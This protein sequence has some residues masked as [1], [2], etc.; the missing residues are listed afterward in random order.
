M[1]QALMSLHQNY[2]LYLVHDERCLVSHW[3]PAS[4]ISM[5]LVTTFV[6]L[7]VVAGRNRKRVG[8]PQTVSRR[9][10]LIHPCHAV[11]MPHPGCAL[12]WPWEV[13]FRT[14]W[15]V[16]ASVNQTRPICANQMGKT[17]SKPLA[18]RNGRGM[19]WARHGHGMLCVNVSQSRW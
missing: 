17:Q 16:T 11:P 13:A 14:A 7:R 18:A 10:M 4:E 8:R 12:S 9:P 2:K 5:I 3:Q 6:E 15:H 19:A 1:I